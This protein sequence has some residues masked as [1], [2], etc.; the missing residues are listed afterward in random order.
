MTDNSI[1]ATILR[2][3]RDGYIIDTLLKNINL[4]LEEYAVTPWDDRPR[5]SGVTKLS[6]EVGLSVTRTG[7]ILRDRAVAFKKVEN[8]N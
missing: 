7:W 6:K 8:E 2:A 4:T 1:E 5:L 3:K